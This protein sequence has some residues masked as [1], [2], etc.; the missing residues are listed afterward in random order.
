MGHLS[1]QVAIAMAGRGRLTSTIMSM[2]GAVPVVEGMG[3]PAE[4]CP[5]PDRD[6]VDSRE[7]HAYLRDRLVAL[8]EETGAETLVFDG[9]SPYP[10][11]GRA[12]PKLPGVKFVWMRRGMW[13]SDVNDRALD[14][15]VYFDQVVEPGDLAASVDSGPTVSRDDA[16]RIAPVSMLAVEPMLSRLEAAA[17]MGIDADRPTLLVTLGTG[18]LG[19]VVGPGRVVLETALEN[20]QWQVCLTKPAIAG[21]GLPNPDPSRVVELSDVYPLVR[22]MAAFDAVVSAS[23]YNAVHEFLP[24]GIPTL[25]VPSPKSVT[26]DQAAR[27][28]WAADEGFALRASALDLESVG[29]ATRQL[30]ESEVRADLSMRC[31]DLGVPTGAHDAVDVIVD[32]TN[33]LQPRGRRPGPDDPG[34][35]A[36]MRWEVQRLIGPA[37]TSKVRWLFNRTADRPDLGERRL[38][39]D[40]SS[41]AGGPQ[42]RFGTDLSLDLLRSGAVVE[43]LVPGSSPRYRAV[44]R[45]IVGR[46]YDIDPRWVAL[47][48]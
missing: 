4:F 23:G 13:I 12:R 46:F 24:A 20:R 39:L 37:A 8:A 43:H 32:R 36:R 21:A 15:S 42:L 27:A 28:G 38:D 19:D 1:R 35:A 16:V 17:A 22:Y 9:V 30:L 41:D 44:R 33:G 26:D 25:F 14:R 40:A 29:N 7:W 2:S 5:G 34:L 3:V 6:W 18:R 10:G 45:T 31:H 47:E 11:I 48:R